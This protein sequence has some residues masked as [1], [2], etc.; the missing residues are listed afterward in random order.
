MKLCKDCNYCKTKNVGYVSY[1]SYC[2][3]LP[4]DKRGVQIWRNTVNHRCPLK[5]NR[6]VIN[7]DKQRSNKSVTKI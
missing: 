1:Y 4:K 3:L 2:M 7:S 6:E 5:E